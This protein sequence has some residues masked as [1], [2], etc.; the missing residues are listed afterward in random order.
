MLVYL[1]TSSLVKRYVGEE[2]SQAVDKVYLESE[3]GRVKVG[4]SIWNVG[5]AIGVL[6]RYRR[7]ELISDDAFQSIIAI[8]ISES[9]KMTR[10]NALRILPI[11]SKVLVE[12][13][14]LVVKHHIC[15]ADALQISSSKEAGCD[16]FLGADSRLIE[17]AQKEGVNAVNIETETRK[18]IRQLTQ[19]K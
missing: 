15:E 1:D 9:L 13:W 5:E 7:R 19:D 8:F 3:A 18:A 2:G 4:F 14:L 16:L 10:L 17:T 12:C 6:D 11:S